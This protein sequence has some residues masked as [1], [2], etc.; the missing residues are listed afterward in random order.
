MI[1]ICKPGDV[2]R[3]APTKKNIAILCKMLP[4]AGVGKSG[5]RRM[6]CLQSP[7]GRVLQI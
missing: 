6:S 1:A 3:T 7:G 4:G 2:T 5:R